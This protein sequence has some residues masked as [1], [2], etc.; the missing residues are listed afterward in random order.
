MKK[1]TLVPLIIFLLGL[2]L[3][4]LIVYITDT[5]EKKQRHTMAQL[6]ATTYGEHIKNEITDGIKI[7]D[8]LEQVIISENGEFHQFDTIAKN[9]MSDSIESMQLAPN[10]IVTDIYPAE[11]N[12]AGKINLLHDKDRKEISCYAKDIPLPTKTGYSLTGW[13]IYTTPITGITL[14]DNETISAIWTPNS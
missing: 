11:G 7:T 1:K 5:H 12:E 14:R 13:Q 3:V 4:S 6:N 8:T 9:L 2:C 10:G